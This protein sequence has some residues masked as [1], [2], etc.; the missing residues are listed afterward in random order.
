LF[1]VG[2]AAFARDSEWLLADDGNLTIT[3]YEHRAGA[4]TRETDVTL[5]IG[6]YFLKGTLHDVNE[7]PIKL[8]SNI[9]SP[10]T[11]NGTI[12]IDYRTGQITLKGKLDFAS[13]ADPI[14][15]NILFQGKELAGPDGYSP[16]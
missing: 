8:V 13:R 9:K 11:F 6:A 12:S 14:N 7:G 10:Y 4:A 5:I 3:T 1:F 2:Q 15:L 16:G